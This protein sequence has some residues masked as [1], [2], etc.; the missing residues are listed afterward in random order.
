MKQEEMLK[1]QVGAAP[2]LLFKNVAQSRLKNREKM[3]S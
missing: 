3:K 1:L 2:L